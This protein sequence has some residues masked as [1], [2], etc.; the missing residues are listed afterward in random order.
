ML[1]RDRW[2]SGTVLR[3]VDS[4]LATSSTGGQR[5]SGLA[6]RML[7]GALIEAALAIADS[8]DPNETSREAEAIV[9]AIV[10]AM[11]LS[12]DRPA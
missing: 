8:D 1:G 5:M 6:S 7:V 2:A 11:N 12:P 4:L 3:A 10:D 9:A